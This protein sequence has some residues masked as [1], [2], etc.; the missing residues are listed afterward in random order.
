MCKWK[1][2]KNKESLFHDFLYDMQRQNWACLGGYE[3]HCLPKIGDFNCFTFHHLN[4][5]TP[6]RFKFTGLR[7][8]ACHRLRIGQ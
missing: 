7:Q 8:T 4:R 1:T 6:Q 5:Y 3:K 2:G